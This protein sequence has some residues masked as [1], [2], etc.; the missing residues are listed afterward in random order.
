MDAWQLRFQELMRELDASLAQKEFKGLARSVIIQQDILKHFER[1]PKKNTSHEGNGA[2]LGPFAFTLTMS[3][4]WGLT[5]SD[6]VVAANKVMSQQ[7][8]KVKKFAWYYEDKGRDEIGNP[9]NPHIHGMYETFTGKRIEIKHF[10]RAWPKWDEDAHQGA[11]FK[12][13]YHRPVK[14]NEAYSDYIKKDGG[15][16]ASFGFSE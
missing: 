6:L 2:Y 11:G 3:P 13:G 4:K 15:M 1:Y 8:C 5:V 12:G 16:S 7:S 14:D 9:K 10:K